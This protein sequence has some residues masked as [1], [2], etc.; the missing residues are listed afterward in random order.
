MYMR[1][2]NCWAERSGFGTFVVPREG[3]NGI[4]PTV[5]AARDE[6][7]G[8]IRVLRPEMVVGMLLEM[9]TGGHPD[10]IAMLALTDQKQ[11]L[12]PRKAWKR[13]KGEFGFGPHS[14]DPWGLQSM[15]KRIYAVRDFYKRE[16]KGI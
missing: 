15:E 10:D 13:K 9:A 16:L 14:D 3:A 4:S 7:T 5:R 6:H 8:L 11:L 1:L 12:G 2:I